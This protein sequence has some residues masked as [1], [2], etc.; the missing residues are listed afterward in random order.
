M[1][2]RKLSRV[3]KPPVRLGDSDS[4]TAKEGF[5]SYDAQISNAGGDGCQSTVVSLKLV[6]ESK[7]R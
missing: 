7:E 3:S 4:G 5:D 1:C 6:G 2:T